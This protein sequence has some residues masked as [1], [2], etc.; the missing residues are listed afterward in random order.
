MDSYNHIIN[1]YAT[2]DLGAVREEF[3]NLTTDQKDN[4]IIRIH[5]T[6]MIDDITKRCLLM[7]LLRVSIGI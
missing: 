7:F 3:M 5:E 4:F 6:D 2:N 1:S